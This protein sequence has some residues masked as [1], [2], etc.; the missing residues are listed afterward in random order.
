[1]SELTQIANINNS[2]LDRCEVGREVAFNKD[3]EKGANLRRET[4]I[5]SV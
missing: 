2:V 1:V 5:P 3:P 4:C